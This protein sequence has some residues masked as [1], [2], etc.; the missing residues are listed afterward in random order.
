MKINYKKNFFLSISSTPG[1]TGSKFHNF[2]Y[3]KLKLN[4]VYVP[5]KLNN[6]SNINFLKD[7]DSIGGFSVSM[8]FKEK[9]IQYI[10]KLDK[11]S[12]K[13]KSVNTVKVEKNKFLDLI[14]I[15]MG[16]RKYLK[17]IK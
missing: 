9:I 10:D 7:N 17:S 2:H 12:K 6:L 4:N 11:I 16:L 14:L 3:K 15:I 5:I 8:P 1:N 13:T